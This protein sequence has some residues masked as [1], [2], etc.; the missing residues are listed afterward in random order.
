[1]QK[2]EIKTVVLCNKNIKVNKV[3]K[4][5]KILFLT[6]VIIIAIF[7]VCSAYAEPLFPFDFSFSLNNETSDAQQ[8]SAS[9]QVLILITILSLAPAIIIMMTSFTRIV[10]ILSFMRNAL[11]TQ[12]MPP[13]QIIIGIA[14]FLTLF[15][16]QPVY[17]DINQKALVPLENE[18][19]N[20]QEALEVS[21][22]IIK[23]FML[24]QIRNEEDLALF[25]SL[26]DIQTPVDPE[27]LPLTVVIPAFLLNELTI[28]F[29]MGFMIYIP[30]LIIDMIV[31]STLMSMGMMMLPPSLISMPF[32]VLLFVLVGGWKLVVESILKSFV[33]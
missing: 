22:D 12:Q 25:V 24:E 14:L 1:M 18:T 16:M 6:I 8:L 20:Q 17:K 19:I 11:G 33:R 21:G 4:I 32:K 13:N 31:S 29:K 15:I 10:I 5:R 23:K 26:S 7:P 28:A 2:K 3:H 27:T 30:F 9:I